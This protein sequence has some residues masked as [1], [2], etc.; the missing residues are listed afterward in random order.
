ML[1]YA[2]AGVNINRGNEFVKRIKPLAK[3]TQT[4]GV[5][6]SLG[7]F[8]GLFD[9]MAKQYKHPLLVA[10]T[11]GVGTKLKLAHLQNKHDTIG[12]DLVAMCVNDLV[13]IGAKPLLFLDYYA[14]GHLKLKRSVDIVRGVAKACRDSGCTLLGGET[15]EMPGLYAREDY[16]LAGFAVGIVDKSKM[17]DGRSMKQGDVVIGLRS[18]GFHSNGYSLVRRVFKPSE[19]KGKIGRRLLTPTQ[20]YVKPVLDIVSRVSV[21][22]MCHITG[23]GF[24]D[25]IPRVL[26]KGLTA[27]I[28]KKS[29][30]IDPLFS[31]VIK[32]ARLSEREAFRTFN[33]GI[34]YIIVVS[35]RSVS[36][37]QRILKKHRVVNAVIGKI[38]KGKE[39]QIQ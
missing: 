35:P 24:Y 19:L 3:S 34:G 9:P 20:L 17:I 32:R 11:D 39:V 7:G 4:R 10:S 25:N 18:S 14:M 37:V 31:E 13:V 6:G 5:V 22:A 1:T 36:Q 33:M 27:M 38:A 2:K 8:S 30:R 23:G 15:A 28:D 21:K 29:W 16:D 26:P 12:I